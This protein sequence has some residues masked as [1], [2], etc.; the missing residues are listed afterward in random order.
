M[1]IFDRIWAIEK[2]LKTLREKREEA[3]YEALPSA[4][5]YKADKVQTS[6]VGFRIEDAVIRCTEIDDQITRLESEKLNLQTQ[7]IKASKILPKREKLAIELRY[8]N[9]ERWK[10]VCCV[11]EISKQRAHK[12]VKQGKAR[13]LGKYVSLANVD[14]EY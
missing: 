3:F 12:L 4:V 7:L 10:Q 9:M 5:A 11:M 8:I 2:D 14:H 6:I 13:I 1:D